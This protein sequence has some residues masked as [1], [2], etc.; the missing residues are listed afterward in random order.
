MIHTA[1]SRLGGRGAGVCSAGLSIWVPGPRWPPSQNKNHLPWKHC[2]DGD[3]IFRQTALAAQQ[4]TSSCSGS[5]GP[6]SSPSPTFTCKFRLWPRGCYSQQ[7]SLCAPTHTATLGYSSR[8]VLA[9]G[10]CRL[11]SK[12]HHNQPSQPWGGP[13]SIHPLSHWQDANESLTPTTHSSTYT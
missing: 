5:A 7:S 10:K 6:C 11:H 2:S 1:K 4:D 12:H 9:R 3:P 13:P 8:K